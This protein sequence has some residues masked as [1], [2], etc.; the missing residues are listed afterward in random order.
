MTICDQSVV[1]QV[2]RPADV[3][4][5]QFR[6]FKREYFGALLNY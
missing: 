2:R 5:L 3:P 4:F 1:Q 6:Q